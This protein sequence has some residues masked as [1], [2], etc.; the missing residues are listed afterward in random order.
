MDAW[1]DEEPLFADDINSDDDDDPPPLPPP[2]P[3]LSQL[4]QPHS[5]TH[6]GTGGEGGSGDGDNWDT[7][8]GETTTG[9]WD[10][11]CINNPCVH[12]MLLE[13][14]TISKVIFYCSFCYFCGIR[15]VYAC[16]VTNL[17]C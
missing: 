6:T 8:R 17:R 11:I 7:P 4:S 3:P 2:M 12:F 5:R 1:D 14:G 10:R 15:M 16:M 9:I 13:M